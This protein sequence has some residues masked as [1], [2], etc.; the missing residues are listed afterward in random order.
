VMSYGALDCNPISLWQVA[1]ELTECPA[2]LSPRLI[3]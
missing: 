1:L 2:D 3:S